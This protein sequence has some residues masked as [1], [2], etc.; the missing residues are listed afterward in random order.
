V[1]PFCGFRAE[2]Q[3][4]GSPSRGQLAGH[5]T[6]VVL[7]DGSPWI[8]NLADLH[9]PN[10]TEILDWFR[11]KVARVVTSACRRVSCVAGRRGRRRSR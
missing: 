9:I 1:K 4:E 5:A 11:A 6:V 2:D 7:G 8:W 3:V 10:R